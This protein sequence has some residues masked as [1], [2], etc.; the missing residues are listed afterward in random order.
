MAS[1]K[2]LFRNAGIFLKKSVFTKI[3]TDLHFQ[4]EQ[5]D[6]GLRTSSN[7]MYS[8]LIMSYILM[9]AL[10]ILI[11]LALIWEFAYWRPKNKLSP[12]SEAGT[13]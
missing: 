10:L 9:G 7:L 11:L 12:T 6:E 8:N 3:V 2:K 1:R 5:G 4:R 13:G